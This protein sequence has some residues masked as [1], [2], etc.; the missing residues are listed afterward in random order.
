[1]SADNTNLAQTSEVTKKVRKP[2]LVEKY[3]KFI[4]FGYYMMSQ[5]SDEDSFTREDFVNQLKVFAPVEEQ[6]TFIQGFLDNQSIIKKRMLGEVRAKNTVTKPKKE[7]APRKTKVN[8]KGNNKKN[9]KQS[10]SGMDD[11]QS[12]L[13]EAITNELTEEPMINKI[14]SAIELA[15][16]LTAKKSRTT[17]KNTTTNTDTDNTPP[18]T[19]DVNQLNDVS[20]NDT[21]SDEVATDLTAVADAKKVR[22]TKKKTSTKTDKNTDN[23]NNLTAAMEELNM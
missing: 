22:I 13:I 19:D 5:M 17:K 7:K 18:T 15:N 14:T 9:A 21:S 20:I 6:Q 12:N 1:M 16:N 11:S 8:A 2:T 4:Q 23:D 10:S 3:S